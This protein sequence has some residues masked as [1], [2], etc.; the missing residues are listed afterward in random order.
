[1]I[2]LLYSDTV[3]RKHVRQV[4]DQEYWVGYTDHQ[5]NLH[6]FLA[7][8]GTITIH[9]VQHLSENNKT[10]DIYYGTLKDG[11]ANLRL[12]GYKIGDHSGV[13]R[14][15]RHVTWYVKPRDGRLVLI[16]PDLKRSVKLVRPPR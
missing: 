12:E 6:V 2:V 9:R 7:A 14:D 3:T 15:I 8:D 5:E 10:E 11:V 4:S 13:Y 1:M 16:M